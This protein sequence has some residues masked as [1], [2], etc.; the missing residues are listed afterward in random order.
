MLKKDLEK[1][2]ERLKKLREEQRLVNFDLRNSND[3]LEN[4]MTHVKS[5]N[6]RRISENKSFINLHNTI[7]L[8]LVGPSCKIS[9]AE[10]IADLLNYEVTSKKKE[11]ERMEEDLK[12]G[13]INQNHFPQNNYFPTY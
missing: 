2:I 8:I 7:V 1:E 12:K 5:E 11:R 3:K 6:E 9:K 4:E 10:A 13:L